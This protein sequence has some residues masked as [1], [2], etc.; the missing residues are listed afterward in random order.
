MEQV[1]SDERERWKCAKARVRQ[2]DVQGV[3]IQII[4]PHN[5]EARKERKADFEADES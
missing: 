2:S 5:Y 1:R 4:T 3:K